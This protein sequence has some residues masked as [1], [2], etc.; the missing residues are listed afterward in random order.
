MVLCPVAVLSIVTVPSV[1]EIEIGVASTKLNLLVLMRNA[2]TERMDVSDAIDDKGKIILL[3]ELLVADRGGGCE[4]TGTTK[5]SCLFYCWCCCW[6][7]YFS[8]GNFMTI[9]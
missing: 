2:Y 7:L 9:W 5:G 3:E 6:A 8:F 4:F 1:L